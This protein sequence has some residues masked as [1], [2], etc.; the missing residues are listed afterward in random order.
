VL[1]E[2]GS[3]LAAVAGAAV[4]RHTDGPAPEREEVTVIRHRHLPPKPEVLNSGATPLPVAEG[5][6]LPDD[7]PGDTYPLLPGY[8]KLSSFEAEEAEKH[9][10]SFFKVY[11]DRYG[12]D[13]YDTIPA[14]SDE[15]DLIQHLIKYELARGVVDEIG[16]KFVVVACNAKGRRLPVAEHEVNVPHRKLPKAVAA[17]SASTLPPEVS[18]AL[19]TLTTAVSNLQTQLAVQQAEAKVRAEMAAASPKNDITTDLL[20]TAIEKLGNPP[21]AST[22]DPLTEKLMTAAIDRLVAAPVTPPAPSNSLK[23]SIGVMGTVVDLAQKMN[24]GAAPENPWIKGA[25]ILVE[26]IGNFAEMLA[27]GKSRADAL[28]ATKDQMSEKLG[29]SPAESPPAAPT[30]APGQRLTWVPQGSVPPA[31]GTEPATTRQPGQRTGAPHAGPSP[32]SSLFDSPPDESATAGGGHA[33]GIPSENRAS[34]PKTSP[35]P[36]TN[37]HPVSQ[38]RRRALPANGG[39]PTV[40]PLDE[41]DVLI[42]SD[43]GTPEQVADL[44][45]SLVAQKKIPRFLL[46]RIASV[47]PEAYPAWAETLGF[48]AWGLPP[49]ASK[50]GA[51]LAIVRQRTAQAAAAK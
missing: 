27:M 30:A 2:E 36:A 38:E 45:F 6:P 50:L 10:P 17:S 47:K 41:L 9:R 28:K 33:G 3:D 49:L 18:S 15:T 20:K 24:P 40:N 42:R 11:K 21:P 5:S 13:Y 23:E 7:D 22:R 8:G 31:P 39:Q 4:P 16:G 37:G 43:S 1:P 48:P 14:T 51:S 44:F 32:S 35:T 29:G 46:G 25:Q 34:A 19:G 12:G 26:G